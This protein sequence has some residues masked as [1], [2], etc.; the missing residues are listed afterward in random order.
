MDRRVTF[1]IGPDGVVE[2][3]IRH[4]ARVWRHL[5]DVLAHLQKHPPS[6]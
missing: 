2:S 4:E 5:D 3:V 1:I 6:A